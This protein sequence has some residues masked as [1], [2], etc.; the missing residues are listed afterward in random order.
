LW[1][2]GVTAIAVIVTAARTVAVVVSLIE[3]AFAKIVAVP[4]PIAWAT[5]FDWMVITAGVS[6]DH[7]AVPVRSI[8]V[9]SFWVPVAV[10]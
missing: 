10:N 1:P 7:A 5:P 8:A 4:L 3:P 6:E 2:A 9:P